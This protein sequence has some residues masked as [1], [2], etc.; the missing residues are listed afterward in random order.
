M[1]L[2]CVLYSTQYTPSRAPESTTSSTSPGRNPRRSGSY[3]ACIGREGPRVWERIRTRPRRYR[4]IVGLPN[5]VS[6]GAHGLHLRVPLIP[7]PRSPHVHDLSHTPRS[8]ASG[9]VP[10]LPVGAVSTRGH[11]TPTAG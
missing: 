2:M 5:F 11:S 8:A 4:Q 6:R 10:P 9:L 3:P 7:R 1:L